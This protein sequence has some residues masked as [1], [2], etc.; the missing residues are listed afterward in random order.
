MFLVLE[1]LL[2]NRLLLLL[3]LL[4]KYIF[5]STFLGSAE[6]EQPFHLFIYIRYIA[7][8][9]SLPLHRHHYSSIQFHLHPSIV[10]CGIVLYI[11]LCPKNAKSHLWSRYNTYARDRIIDRPK[12]V[13]HV[14]SSR[15]KWSIGGCL[16]FW[17]NTRG[18]A[19]YENS[20]KSSS[21]FAR[22]RRRR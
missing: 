9:S 18:A 15:L 12:R 11:V 19:S 10:F 3:F 13:F 17:Y 2:L 4:Y 5:I 7:H 21:S 22:R 6:E 14:A 20:Y 16:V 8:A 1:P